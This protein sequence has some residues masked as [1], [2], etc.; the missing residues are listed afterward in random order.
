MEFL[1]WVYVKYDG[2]LN[3]HVMNLTEPIKIKNSDRFVRVKARELDIE[4]LIIKV[5]CIQHGN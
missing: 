4:G 2:H 1:E 3:G 5:D